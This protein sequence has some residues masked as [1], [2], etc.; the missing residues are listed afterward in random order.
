MICARFKRHRSVQRET[1]IHRIGYRELHKHL[2]WTKDT[3]RCLHGSRPNDC[4]KLGL[5]CTT[6]TGFGNYLHFEENPERILIYLTAYSIGARWMA[7]AQI[8]HTSVLST[9]TDDIDERQ[10]LLRRNDCCFQ[11]AI[12]Q[13]AERPGKWFI[14]L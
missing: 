11:C 2:W 4:V 3:R 7:L 12:D 5:D 8:P 1:S 14:V 10:I 13:A 6:I 9:D